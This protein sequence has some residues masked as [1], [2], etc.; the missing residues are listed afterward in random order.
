MRKEQ[1]PKFKKQVDAAMIGYLN[2]LERKELLSVSIDFHESLVRL[3]PMVQRSILVI[4]DTMYASLIVETHA[5][6]FDKSK[7]SSNLS[8]SQLLNLLVDGNFNLKHLLEEYVKPPKTI[9]LSGQGES[10]QDRFIEGRKLEFNQ[11]FSDCV[12]C[13]NELLSSGLVDRVKL[14]RDGMLAHKDGN[15]DMTG[16]GNTIQD[17]F[18][19]L[20]HMKAILVSLNKLL[21]RISYPISESEKSAKESAERFWNQLART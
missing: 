12:T 2:L 5:W 11:S 17:I 15:Y 4:Q 1:I 20:S 8:L 19:L 3:E 16:N 6:L 10:W 7:K 21:Q 9:V 14:L 18:S 13:I